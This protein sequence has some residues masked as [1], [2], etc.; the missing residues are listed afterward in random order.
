[1]A[2]QLISCESA[3]WKSRGGLNSPVIPAMHGTE[4]LDVRSSDRRAMG[5]CDLWLAVLI[6]VGR[7]PG[8]ASK[9][10]NIRL[11][12]HHKMPEMHRRQGQGTTGTPQFGRIIWSVKPNVCCF[13]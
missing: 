13:H 4:W 6:D 11:A 10:S 8:D 2:W 12:M 3:S 9:G 5:Q 1:M 7:A